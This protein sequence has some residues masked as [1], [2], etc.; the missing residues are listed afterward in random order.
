LNLPGKK[1]S[2]WLVDIAPHY[3]DL[4]NFPECEAK[5]DLEA[6][7]RRVARSKRD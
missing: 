4:E 2:D 7:Y 3:Y 5:H 6:V 1:K